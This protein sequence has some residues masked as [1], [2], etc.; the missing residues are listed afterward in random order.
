MH[1][2][3]D[4]AWADRARHL[5]GVV[6]ER[7]FAEQVRTITPDIQRFDEVMDGVKWALARCPSAFPVVD[8]VADVRIVKTTPLGGIPSLIVLLKFNEQQTR[9][10]WVE[11]APPDGD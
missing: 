4:V 1:G 10:L 9:L 8:E 3:S 11:V 5:R 6:E 7:T 2:S